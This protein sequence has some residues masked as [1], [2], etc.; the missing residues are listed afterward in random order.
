MVKTYS[1]GATLKNKLEQLIIAEGHNPKP[2]A[3]QLVTIANVLIP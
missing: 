2:V 1:D 3:A